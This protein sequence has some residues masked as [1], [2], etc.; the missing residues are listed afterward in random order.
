[1]TY[2]VTSEFLSKPYMYVYFYVHVL[3]YACMSSLSTWWYLSLGKA[4]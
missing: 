1:M 3:M 4:S 2:E